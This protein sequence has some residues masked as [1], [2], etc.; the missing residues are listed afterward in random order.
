[1]TNKITA[2]FSVAALA[3]VLAT[4][5]EASPKP[6]DRQSGGMKMGGM[7]TQECR[8][9]CREITGSMSKL[10]QV[11]EEAKKSG[12]PA[13]M[14]AALDQVEKQHAGMDQ[15]MS[16]C[17]RAMDNIDKM[18]GGMEGKKGMQHGSEKK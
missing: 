3:A 6:Q 8:K 11:I 16:M 4:G 2:L 1:M 5:Q 17:M 9:H 10:S 18:H 15:H 14:R 12:D 7:M 13:K